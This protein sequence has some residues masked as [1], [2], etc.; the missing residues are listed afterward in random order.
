MSR[1][2][3]KISKTATTLWRWSVYGIRGTRERRDPLLHT[4][5][6]GAH[7]ARGGRRQGR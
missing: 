4:A 5:P 7:P 6:R 1:T 2:K 3:Q